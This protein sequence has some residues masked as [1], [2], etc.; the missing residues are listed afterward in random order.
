M[1]LTIIY[2]TRKRYDLFV[3]STE[4]LIEKCSDVNNFFTTNQKNERN[5]DTYLIREYLTSLKWKRKPQ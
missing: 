1:K 5:R 2:P 4:S 3:K